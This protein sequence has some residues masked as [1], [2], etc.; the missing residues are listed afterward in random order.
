MWK[1]IFS[2]IFPIYI[3]K[4]P[5]HLLYDLD[6]ING[7]LVVSCFP[8]YRLPPPELN[9]V[10]FSVVW[11]IICCSLW[12]KIFLSIMASQK[13][14]FRTLYM[15]KNPTCNLLREAFPPCWYKW[16]LLFLRSSLCADQNN[17]TCLEWI[18][19]V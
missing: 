1:R 10:L 5:W 13:F 4:R 8:V 2:Y 19:Y 16:Q 14:P 9:P 11:Q 3:L 6:L 17:S 15:K 12:Q 18:L 7:P